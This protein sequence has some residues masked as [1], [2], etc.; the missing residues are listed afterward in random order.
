M[1][2]GSDSP[3]QPV[4]PAPYPW[5]ELDVKDSRAPS[6]EPHGN[7]SGGTEKP[8]SSAGPNSETAGP[9]YKGFTSNSNLGM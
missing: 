5:A 8:T 7:E 4:Q 2:F 3:Q 9:A 1:C 6:G